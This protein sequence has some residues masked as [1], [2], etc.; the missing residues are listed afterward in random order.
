MGFLGL[1]K[2]SC[3]GKVQIPG[4]G[5]LGWLQT[6]AESD[7][8]GWQISTEFIHGLCLSSLATKV[9]VVD[10]GGE[11]YCPPS[12]WTTHVEG[13][14]MSLLVDMELLGLAV[15]LFNAKAVRN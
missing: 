13:L 9:V 8:S 14:T 1:I 5:L 12:E 4:L 3:D 15:E 2:A 10:R 11:L 7:Y 6:V